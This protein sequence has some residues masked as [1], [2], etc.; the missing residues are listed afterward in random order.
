[1]SSSIL[2]VQGIGQSTAVNLAKHGIKTIEDLAS[3]DVAR[4]MTV[5][6]FSDIRAARII[7]A[8]QQL[9]STPQPVKV[10]IDEAS[11]KKPVSGKEAGTK[12]RKKKSKKKSGK[13]KGKPSKKDKSKKKGKGKKSSKKKKK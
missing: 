8:A 4:L 5:K 2:E 10:K 9:L 12:N 11:P 7:S 3:A 1:M 13:E 6:G